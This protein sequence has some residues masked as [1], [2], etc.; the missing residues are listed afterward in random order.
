[1]E[2][3]IINNL[4]LLILLILFRDVDIYRSVWCMDAPL[5]TMY[6]LLAL[7]R[8]HNL[9]LPRYKPDSSCVRFSKPRKLHVHPLLNFLTITDWPNVKFRCSLIGPKVRILN[10]LNPLAPI[11]ITL[12]QCR[13]PCEL[14]H[15]SY[16]FLLVSQRA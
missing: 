12:F 5:K 13:R 6:S 8:V 11:Y 14:L 2:Q 4:S 7:V 16:W 1:M 9:S 15:A 3:Y 10:T